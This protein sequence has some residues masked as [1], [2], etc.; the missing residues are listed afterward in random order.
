MYNVFNTH[1][2]HYTFTVHF[3]HKRHKGHKG[4][5][6]HKKGEK[7]SHITTIANQKGGVGKT[8]TAHALATGLTSK[9]YKVLLIDM[10]PQGNLSYTMGADDQANGTYE[11][12]KGKEKAVDVIQHTKQGDI[13][14]SSLLLAGADLEFCDT[15]REYLLSDALS[16][17][18]DN[19]DYI[20]IDT[21][22]TLGILTINALTFSNDIIIPMGADIYS[23]Q[24][25]SQLY[26]AIGKVRQYCNRG[27]KIS[28]LLFTR[29]NKRA[30]LSR[31]LKETI[32]AKA[33]QIEA[34]VYKTAI[35]EGIAVKEIQTQ[36]ASMYN[37][38]PKT[39][40]TKDYL[41]FVDEYLQGDKSYE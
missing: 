17:V 4:H 39:N 24:G 25:L 35:R 32:E 33:A 36:Q 8:T 34:P 11:L 38:S 10:D 2:T 41:S 28:G 26:G 19:Y 22:P 27:L 12:L 21:P 31:E 37:V 5:I 1:K 13:I 7:M 16:T 9:G 20:I 3:G 30:I 6:K 18:K 15:G 23:L 40:T 29:F 14:A